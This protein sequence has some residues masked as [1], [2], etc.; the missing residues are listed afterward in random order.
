MKRRNFLTSILA[1]LGAVGALATIGLSSRKK[2]YLFVVKFSDGFIRSFEG[3]CAQGGGDREGD[4]EQWLISN[5]GDLVATIGEDYI[6]IQ[7]PDFPQPSVNPGVVFLNPKPPKSQLL[8]FYRESGEGEVSGSVV[9]IVQR[10]EHNGRLQCEV[11]SR[12]P[13]KDARVSSYSWSSEEWKDGVALDD[14]LD[15]CRNVT[16]VHLACDGGVTPI[17]RDPIEIIRRGVKV[18][19]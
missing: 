4:R 5:N 13:I 6:S 16:R 1:A 7:V 18:L 19:V 10:R 11:I 14:H 3:D 17:P 12:D 8:H 9:K 15:Y 2:T